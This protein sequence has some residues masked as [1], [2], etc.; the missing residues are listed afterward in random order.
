MS[1]LVIE[2]DRDRLIIVSGSPSGSGVSVQRALTLEL[3]AHTDP[4]ESGWELRHALSDAGISSDAAAV[5][6]PRS[7]VTLRRIQLPNVSDDELPEMVKLQ[8]A[9]RLTVPIDSVCMDYVPLPLPGEGRDVL[10]AT[11]PT[12]QITRIQR[13]VDAAGLQL[14]GVH[15]SSFGIATALARSRK[16][17]SVAESVEA[18]ISLRADM[19][20]L[21][22]LQ[23][24]A[25]VFSHSGASW[26]TADQI[27]QAVR[28]EI[29]RGRMA[30]TEDIGSHTVTQVTLVGSEDVM[31]AVPD[32]V[33]K[34]L[35]N[36]AIRRINPAEAIVQG[37]LP[38]DLT[39]SDVL[40]AAG[41]IA[42]RPKD[43]AGSVDL[44][45]PRKAAERPDNRR[46]K[47]ILTVGAVLLTV[48][49]MW[50]WRDSQIAQLRIQTQAVERE[51]S[52]LTS[53]YKDGEDDLEQDVAIREWSQRNTDWLEEMDRI[54]TIMGGTDRLLIREIT[55]STGQGA[56]R[57]TI[58]AECYAKDRHDV[59]A[60][61][62]RL[63]EAGYD[64]VPRPIESG[65]R[66]PDYSSQFLLVLDLPVEEEEG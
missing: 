44:V 21:L 51:V 61:H 28:S 45:N 6:L 66:D 23:R 1:T 54:R 14:S 2:W 56:L 59:D 65:S 55:C 50:K 24:Q 30:A 43:R 26:N 31:S 63:E 29:S 47:V 41:V 15:V 12:D 60:F 37:P 57:G 4:E 35:D 40:A 33:T 52:N 34:R 38:D 46:L 9:T 13:T 5:V 62:R 19:I 22:I 48:V 10:L 32:A 7:F 8:A 27:E 11:A 49:G 25:V 17:D 58:T 36:A 3:A 20:E 16:N 39:A 18:V 64:V 53:D 42:A